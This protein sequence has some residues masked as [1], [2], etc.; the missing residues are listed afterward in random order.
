MLSWDRPKILINRVYIINV[1]LYLHDY[2]FNFLKLPIPQRL[3]NMLLLYGGAAWYKT[4]TYTIFTTIIQLDVK[5]KN[6]V[7]K[8]EI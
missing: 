1:L 5:K 3:M 6:R 7:A 2:A 8:C 4:L